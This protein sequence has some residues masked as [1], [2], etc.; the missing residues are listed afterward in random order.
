MKQIRGMWFPDSDEHLAGQLAIN[1]L[2][3]GRGTYQYRKYARAMAHVTRCGHAVDIGAQVGL[4]S[5][6]MALDF[7]RVTAFEPL[8]AHLECFE[9]N[10]AEPLAAGRIDL[11]RIALDCVDGE[12]GIAMPAESTG[13]SHVAQGGE[14]GQVVRALTLDSFGL[15]GID[16][17][18]IDV[19]GFEKP[20]LEGGEQTIRCEKPVIIIEQKPNGNAERYGRDRFA[21][22]D[23]LKAW[24]GKVM[25]E[26]GGD[27]LVE[28]K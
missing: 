5:R 11:H 10:L 12:L 9:R 8:P 16:F 2:V 17:L 6:V 13:N 23:L 19:E 22:L 24:G 21:A 20:I 27:F 14:Q 28:W 25:W 7:A 18:K 15:A 26:I 1:P 3:D 4:W